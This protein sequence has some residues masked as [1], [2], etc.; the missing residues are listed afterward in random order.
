MAEQ[1]IETKLK[2]TREDF[3]RLRKEGTVREKIEQRNFYYDQDEE[4]SRASATFRIRFY[5]S[6]EPVMTLKL[7]RRGK[8]EARTCLEVES[9]LDDRDF[10]PKEVDVEQDLPDEFSQPLRQLGVRDLERLG[11]MPNSRFLVCLTDDLEVEMD[12]ARLP[13]GEEFYEVEFESDDLEEHHR[14]KDLIHS[15]VSSAHSSGLSKYER[16]VRALNETSLNGVHSN[17]THSNGTHDREKSL[18]HQK[19]TG[20]GSK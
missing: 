8:G 14:A 10:C 18:T 11:S 13:T 12:R 20:F 4:L 17:G 9:K 5:S 3:E 16:F 19:E 15:L 6:G 2:V 7:P 1:E